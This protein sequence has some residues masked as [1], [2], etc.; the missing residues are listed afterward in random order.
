MV[1]TNASAHLHQAQPRRVA[2]TGATRR[3][4]KARRIVTVRSRLSDDGKRYSP[5]L[6]GTRGMAEGSRQTYD[7]RRGGGVGQDAMRCSSKQLL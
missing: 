3:R 2:S 4:T 6:V 5:A 7:R 1:S